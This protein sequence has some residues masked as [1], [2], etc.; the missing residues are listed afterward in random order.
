MAR[1]NADL[2]KE[3]RSRNI[4]FGLDLG[5]KKDYSALSIIEVQEEYAPVMQ[6]I[7]NYLW[8]E[9]L[10]KIRTDRETVYNVR[11]VTRYPLGTLYSKIVELVEGAYYEVKAKQKIDPIVVI[12]YTGVGTAVYEMFAKT[13]MNTKGVL[14]HAGDQWTKKAN[15]YNVPKRDLC[16][17]VR[18]SMETGSLL[19]ANFPQRDILQDELS[20]FEVSIN[21]KGHDQYGAGLEGWRSGN[22]DD[23]VLSIAI[24]LW[25]AAKRLKR[26][27][28]F[29]KSKLGFFKLDR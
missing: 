20:N 29:D 12:D 7:G 2:E 11:H 16:G 24:G 22:H 23:M 15:V 25:F 8:A 19:I 6:K 1:I 5:L 13:R 17:I 4:V 27:R 14:I 9:D 26:I 18:A 21:E 10:K 28:T 3:L